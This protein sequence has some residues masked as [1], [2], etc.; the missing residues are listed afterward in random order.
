MHFCFRFTKKVKSTL[1]VHWT[2]SDI[3]PYLINLWLLLKLNLSSLHLVLWPIWRRKRQL[4]L[5]CSRHSFCYTRPNRARDP[6]F[7]VYLLIS[8]IC[9][10]SA[11]NNMMANWSAYIHHAYDELHLNLT[12]FWTFLG[13]TQFQCYLLQFNASIKHMRV[14]TCLIIWNYRY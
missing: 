2:A 10:D 8:Y 14:N 11:V 3:I 13:A 1:N 12:I 5:C 6:G 7:G 4:W 9:H